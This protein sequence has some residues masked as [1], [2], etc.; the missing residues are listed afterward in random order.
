M[1]GSMHGKGMCG[2]E[3]N[4]WAWRVKANAKNAKSGRQ[5]Q[6]KGPSPVP[7]PQLEGRRR[8]PR[9]LFFF[10]GRDERVIEFPKS[11]KMDEIISVPGK[12]TDY[13]DSLGAA[14]GRGKE[15]GL[16]PPTST[17]SRLCAC[18]GKM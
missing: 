8:D 5:R 4:V 18:V 2:A 13:R 12:E 17:P 9:R 11:K 15:K 14:G 7:P 1:C 6:G 16:I 3:A 10:G